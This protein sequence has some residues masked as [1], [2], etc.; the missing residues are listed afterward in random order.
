M[1]LAGTLIA[2]LRLQYNFSRGR[3]LVYSFPLS[4]IPPSF[5]TLQFSFFFLTIRQN[6]SLMALFDGQDSAFSSLPSPRFPGPKIDLTSA[7]KT[8]TLLV[9]ITTGL[10]MLLWRLLE[11]PNLPANAPPLWQRDDWPLVGALRFFTARADMVLEAVDAHS[12]HGSGN[13]S[14]YLGKKHVVGIGPS[15]EARKM[16]FDNKDMSLFQG[17]HLPRHLSSS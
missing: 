14:F 3:L 8:W 10:F 11:R 15:A 2:I 7:N 5:N 17:Y 1:A 4:D 13:F 12:R 6:I 9:V 16:F